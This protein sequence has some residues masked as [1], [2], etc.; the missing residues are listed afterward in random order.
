MHD[1]SKKFRS[2]QLKITVNGQEFFG[3]LYE[4]A[5]TKDL[6]K[7]LPVT[8]TMKE[9]NGNEKYYYL[10]SQLPVNAI[11][12]SNIKIGDIMLYEMIT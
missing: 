9:L 3:N 6:V 12:P 4:N 5:T 2:K 11:I 8:I 10:Q 1:N 7:A